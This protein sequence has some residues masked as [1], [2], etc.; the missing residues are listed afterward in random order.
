MSRVRYERLKIINNELWNG[1]VKTKYGLEQDLE[2]KNMY[3][4][5][6][7][8]GG[9]SDYFYTLTSGVDALKNHYIECVQ[10]GR[11]NLTGEF[12]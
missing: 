1:R 3:W 11:I 9:K 12:K 2:L 7:P 6:F 8:S 4:I 10:K 5:T